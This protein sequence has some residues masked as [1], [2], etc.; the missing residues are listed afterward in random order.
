MKTSKL[1][2][3][4]QLGVSDKAV[5]K[6]LKRSIIRGD[7]KGH[8]LIINDDKYKY[9]GV[10]TYCTYDIYMDDDNLYGGLR[11]DDAIWSF[12]MV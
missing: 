5:A 9:F 12:K 3:A 7:L 11:A 10:V 6:R 2:V 4:K 8:T 1:Q